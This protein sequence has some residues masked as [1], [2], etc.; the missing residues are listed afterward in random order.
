MAGA[1]YSPKVFLQVV[2]RNRHQFYCTTSFGVPLQIRT[3][4]SNTNDCSHT[5]GERLKRLSGIPL[6]PAC[7]SRF[8]TAD[9][10]KH[11]GLILLV[12]NGPDHLRHKLLPFPLSW[13]CLNNTTNL[14]STLSIQSISHFLFIFHKEKTE[15]D[16]K[17][18]LPKATW[19]QSRCKNS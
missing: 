13:A 12:G 17:C 3:D 1:Q 7:L 19:I 10:Y 5:C 15:A 6:G 16:R 11:L 14:S 18:H 8:R 9:P 2:G 4:T